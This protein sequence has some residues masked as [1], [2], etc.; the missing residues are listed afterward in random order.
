[1]LRHM[2]LPLFVALVTSLPGMAVAT[3]SPVDPESAAPRHARVEA[4]HGELV[5]VLGS[6]VEAIDYGRE[7]WVAASAEQLARLRSNGI[8]VAEVAEPF[9]LD[10]GGRRFDPLTGVPPALAEWARPA[11]TDG[12]DWRLVQFSGPVRQAWLDA[13]RA[14]RLEPAQYI[15]PFTYVVWGTRAALG[16]AASQP[17]VRWTGDFLPAYRILPRWRAL[18]A[19]AVTVRASVHAGTDLGAGLRS[20]GATFLARG[21][22]DRHFS[23]VELRIAGNRLAALAALPGVYSIQPLPT[24]GGLRGEMSDQI[25]AGNY[26]EDNFAFPGYLDYLAGIGVDGNGVIIANVDGGIWDT[27]PDLV[28]RM[29]SCAG[30]T[31]GGSQTDSHGTHTAGIMAADGSSGTTTANGFLRGL[32]MAPGANLVEQVYSPFFTQPGGMLKL[33]TDSVRNDAVVSGN[34]WGPAGSPRGYDDDT[35]QVD[36]GVRDSDPDAPGDQPLSYVL[37]FMNGGGGFQSQGTPDEGKNLF[38]IGSTKMQTSATAQIA[39]IDDLSSNSAHGPALDGRTIPAMVAPGCSVDST[40]S[41]T[42][43]GLLCGTS[44]ASPH[45]TGA[46]ALFVEYYRNLTGDDPSPALEKAAFT[47]VAKDLTGHD[48]ADGI[49]IQQLFD[50]KQGWGRMR[51][52]PVLAPENAVAYIDQDVVFDA[53]GESW[54]QTFAAADP[55]APMRLMLVWTD[56][57]GHGLGGSTPAWNNDLNLRVTGAGGTFLGNV[58]DGDGWSATGGSADAMNNT[59]AVFLQAAQHGGSISVEVLAT[60]I[61]SDALP[62]AGDD[63]DQDFALVCYNCVDAVDDAADIAV[64]VST[65]ADSVQAGDEIDYVVQ[66]GND[67]PAD[68]TG[69]GVNVFAAGLASANVDAASGWNCATLSTTLICQASDAL[70]AGATSTFTVNGIVGAGS[71][72][73]LVTTFSAHADQTDANTANDVVSIE[74]PL[75]SDRIFAGGFEP[76]PTR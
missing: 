46:V 1:M 23:S 9:T 21:E 35:R 58:L 39:Q 71:G 6:R 62:N 33:M 64:S 24:D 51:I 45:V 32:G 13:L 76:V 30:D 63:T 38:T 31:C 18:D 26:D 66:V 17:A 67:G 60:D 29:L 41:S 7:Q 57:P 34:S 8:A 59:E 68:A 74:T 19:D 11:D 61:N 40:I 3:G 37:S 16:E 20:A 25:N 4:T 52:D 55:A 42:G 22:V 75:D 56:A 5:A 73:M 69:V 54:S 28:G 49:P 50:S 43:Y 2:I 12:A 27:H 14:V 44:M 15:H 72:D 48:D 70:P 53:T 36:V 47:A 10:L 65:D